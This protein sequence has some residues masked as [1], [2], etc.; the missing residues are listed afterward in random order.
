MAIIRYPGSKAKLFSQI[1]KHFPDEM[2][3]PIYSNANPIEYREPFFGSG[4]FGLE[5]MR[6]C[7]DFRCPVWVN[8]IDPG[9]VALWTAI[10]DCP[11]RLCRL[12]QDFVP[13]AD[14]FYEF[15]ELDGQ[16]TGEY[17]TDGFRKL[18]LHRMSMSGFGAMSGGPIGGRSQAGQYTVECRW[19]PSRIK[20]DIMR[21]H[22]TMRR[23]RSL[24]ITC[25]DFA[26]LIEGAPRE[27]FIYLDPPYYEKGAQLYKYNMP[28]ECHERMAMMLRNCEAGWLVSYDDHPTIRDLYADAS[29]HPIFVTYSNAVCKTNK[30]PKNQEIVIKRASQVMEKSA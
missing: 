13:S 25:G 10:R 14:A 20:R 29:I 15:K 16:L 2:R 9:V 22:A 7:I 21:T 11:S 30:R 23:F 27:C 6:E 17:A 24:R 3:L 4:E 1:H 26:D 28:H 19:N 8:D 18:A 5:L 12:V